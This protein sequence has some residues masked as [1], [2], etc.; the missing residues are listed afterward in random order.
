MNINDLLNQALNM[1]REFRDKKLE[2]ILKDFIPIENHIKAVKN[3]S[4]IR[5]R[6]IKKVFGGLE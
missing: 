6:K 5:K 3:K 1:E 2:M 4:C